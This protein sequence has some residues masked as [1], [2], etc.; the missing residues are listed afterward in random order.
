MYQNK[1]DFQ[2]SAVIRGGQEAPDLSGVARF[3]QRSD[4]VLVTI[5]VTGLPAENPGGFFGLHIHGGS[6]CAGENFAG[7]GGHFNPAG[8]P[9]PA[10]AGDLPPLLSCGG[11]A[12][13]AV[14]TDRFT[15]AD[16]IGRTVVIHGGSD[17][18]RSQPAGDA[19][20][21]IACGVIKWG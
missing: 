15:V 5:Q 2:A 10:H 7:T 9:H 19:G 1:N 14:L 21:K 16:I 3:F 8:T 6:G 18:F 20:T 12:Y 13:L 4:G 11:R 17:D